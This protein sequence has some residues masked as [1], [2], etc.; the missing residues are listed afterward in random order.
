MNFAR[1]FPADLR[2]LILADTKDAADNAEQRENR[3][4]MIEVAKSKGSPAIAEL[5]IGKLLSPDALEHRPDLVKTLR[6]MMEECPALT[7]EHALAA[8][9]DRP[10]MTDVLPEIKTPSLIIVGDAD[11]ITPVAV[12]EGM[13]KR[14]AGSQL[15]VIAGAGHMAPMEQPSMVNRAI[16]QFVGGL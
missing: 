4:R 16:R 5:M 7:I 3:N 11:A 10:D 1:K 12:A 9:R 2:G 14:I 15:A 13:H 6:R 8:M